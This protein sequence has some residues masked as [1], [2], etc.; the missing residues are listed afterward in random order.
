MC[1]IC[2][3]IS[4]D[5]KPIDRI[6][7]ENMTNTLI[8]RGPDDFGIYINGKVGLG[9]RRLSIIDITSAGH[10]PMTNEDKSIWLTYNGEIYN[11]TELK[12]YLIKKGHIFK[13]HTDT[14]MVIHSYE[15]WGEN[16]IEK[17][18]GMFAFGL[19]D[20]AQKKLFLARDRF[21]KKP[22]YYYSSSNFF[23]FA[24]EIKAII[25]H[26]AVTK[27]INIKALYK[28]FLFE[29]IP[30][31]DSIFEN[32]YK[33]DAGTFL[34]LKDGT[35]EIKKYW[36]IKF[37]TQNIR[38]EEACENIIALLK[39]SIKLRLISDVPLGIFLSGGI[40]S[41]AITTLL[42]EMMPAGKIK[43]FSIGFED[44]SFDESNYARRMADY[45][46]VEHYEEKLDPYMMINILPEII[47]KLDEPFADNSIIP[48]Y[49]LSKFTRNYVTVALGG[50]GGDELFAGYDTFLANYY[51]RNFRVPK[52]IVKSLSSVVK[53]I[54]PVSENNISPDFIIKKTL[55]GL[56]YNPE[57]R[58][59]VWL[60]A[61][62]MEA[63]KDL[64]LNYDK[65][66]D[67]LSPIKKLN[68]DNLTLIQKIILSYIKLYLLGDILTKVDRASMMCSLEVRAP[69][70]DYEFAEYV[71]N[72]KDDFK[73][74]HGMRKYILKKAM[75]SKMPDE[76]I[77][78]KK[79]GFGIPLTRWLK[80][81]LKEL[82]LDNLSSEKINADGIFNYEYIKKLIEAHLHNKKDNRK[83]LWALLI[84]QLWKGRYYDKQ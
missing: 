64:F 84:F 10:Q 46:G 1:G 80:K 27:R 19:Y 74:R 83:E 73:I 36:D 51:L 70:L 30:E 16:C 59:Q 77:N 58:E 5:D 69:F 12:K 57:I 75:K 49:L 38:E 29:Y 52:I 2:G 81:E 33:L 44:E 66:I 4:F 47:E 60:G 3:V 7:L 18:N 41:S 15:E 65:E 21:G 50:D 53:K 14:E 42:S 43:T 34:I 23:I 9:H 39:K 76:I 63:Q 71:N 11:F 32:I 56:S 54:F 82:M 48:T 45:L 26:P 55:D 28:Y 62:S 8:H 68:F 72:L 13:S 78:R 35:A 20:F 40:D 37:N 67:V 24:S 61:F 25:A 17:F 79:K 6:I 31:P 22:L